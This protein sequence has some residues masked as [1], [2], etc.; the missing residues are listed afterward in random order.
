MENSFQTSFIPK[1]PITTEPVSTY[2]SP[3]SIITVFFVFLLI[4]MG[5]ISGGLFFYKIYLQN[6]EK[7]LSDSLATAS[8]G[9]D[10]N[11][12]D[13]L[14]LFDKR[15]TVSKQLLS[16]HIIMTPLFTLLGQLTIPSIQFT[17][18]SQTDDI[19]KGFSVNLSG[20]AQDYKS[21]ALQ[22]DAFNSDQGHSFKNVIFSNLTKDPSGRVLFDVAFTVDPNLLSYEKNT[23]AFPAVSVQT[24]PSPSQIQSQP[25]VSV[26]ISDTTIGASAPST[27]TSLPQTTTTPPITNTTNQ[28]TTN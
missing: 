19:I 8:V 24:T 25:A 16:S 17:K 2:K 11:T 6:Q 1:K 14:E 10:K 3:T 7:I 12:V 28:K 15:S 21:I 26:P 5:I 4:G 22:A 13:E 18:F 23:N 27:T 9:F 20:S